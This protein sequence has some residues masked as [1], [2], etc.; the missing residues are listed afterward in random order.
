MPESDRLKWDARYRE[1]GGARPDPSPLLT[2]LDAVLPR[3]GRAIDVAGGTGRHALWLTRRG[4]D[5]TLA[6]ISPV[7]L[8]IATRAAEVEGL[9][10]RTLLIDLEAEPFPAGPW[11]CVLVFHFLWRPLLAAIPNALA[12]GGVVAVVHPTRTNLTRHERPGPEHLLHDGELPGLIRGLDL[13]TSE[14]GWLAEGRHEARLVARKPG[15]AADG[16]RSEH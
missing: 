10:L 12:P 13:L 15:V 9:P 8:E 4:L 16:D 1:P 5:V 14:E 7:A 3:R 2:S 11:D 6:D